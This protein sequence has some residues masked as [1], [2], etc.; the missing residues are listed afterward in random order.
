MRPAESVPEDDDAAE[1]PA[2]RSPVERAAVAFPALVLLALLLCSFMD[3]VGRG[4]FNSPLPGAVELSELM[5]ALLVAS[6][7]PLVTAKR[8]HIVVDFL[9]PLLGRRLKLIQEALVSVVSVVLLAILA[10]RLA[11]QTLD[12]AAYNAITAFLSVPTWP[13]VGFMAAMCAIA[14]VLHLALLIRL[15]RHGDDR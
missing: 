8:A 7:L 1:R 13:V 4:L 2:A 6:A 14:G 15:L 9:D 10:W 11:I 12:M 3:V 5:M